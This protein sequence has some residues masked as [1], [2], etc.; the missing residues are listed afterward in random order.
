[1]SIIHKDNGPMKH[2]EDKGFTLVELLVAMAIASMVL[3]AVVSAYYVQ[4]RGQNTQEALTDM[5]QTARAAMEIM[6]GEIRLA[7]CDVLKSSGAT[8]LAATANQLSFTM[9][10]GDGVTFQP[11]GDTTDPNESVIYSLY[12]DG[13][14]NQNLGRD[15]GGGPQ[16]LAR[17]VDALDFVYFDENGNP[18]GALNDIRSIQINLVARAGEAAGG[19]LHAFTDTAAYQNQQGN[20]ILAAQNDGFRRLQLSTTANCYN[21]RDKE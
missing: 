5:N 18:P 1:M 12:V 13:D 3:A 6:V 15:T 14:G 17:N 8:I 10:I 20:V 19:F 9:D 7:G 2:K 11:D 21:M 16:P 4:V